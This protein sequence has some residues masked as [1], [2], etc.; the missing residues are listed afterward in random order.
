VQIFQ[1]IPLW[2]TDEPSGHDT[3]V[4]SR[5]SGRIT[6][7]GVQTPPH[8]LI[9]VNGHYV[10]YPEASSS[11]YP[12]PDTS[13]S[14]LRVDAGTGRRLEVPAGLDQQEDA[15]I[16][17]SDPGVTDLA[18]AP[19]GA[20]AWIIA[21]TFTN[22]RVTDVYL[23]PAGSMTPERLAGGEAVQPGSLMVGAG[24]IQWHEGQGVREA[25]F[26]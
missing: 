24:I 15:Y 12:E 19:D 26:G 2:N 14:I 8:P 11:R 6:N 10:A 3:F 21:G 9:E 7:I 5:Q 25:P 16:P 1:I 23:L 22:P 4:R 18:L 20:L 13:W 17:R